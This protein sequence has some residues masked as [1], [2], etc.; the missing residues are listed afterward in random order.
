[1]TRVFAIVWKDALVRFSSKMEILFFL[2]LPVLFT[3]LLSGVGGGS[4]ENIPL[5][6]VDQ[7]ASRLSS[8]LVKALTRNTD[9]AVTV[10][11]RA[12]AESQFQNRQAVAWVVIPA[13]L[14]AELMTNRPAT[15]ELYKATGNASADVAEQAVSS[16]VRSVNRSIAVALTSTAVAERLRPFAEIA[17]RQ[18]YFMTSLTAAQEITA[19]VPKRLVVAR[20][21]TQKATLDER[22]QASIGQ[23]V[24][25]VLIPLLGTSVL[26]AYERN[27][28]TLQ[29]LLTTPTRKATYLSG[30]I[31]GQ[32]AVA[33]VQMVVLML[34][35]IYVMHVPWG[36]SPV[37][38]AIMMV[39]FGLASVALGT[40]L[41][42]FIKTERQA[43]NLSILL[44]MVLS[45]LGGCWWPLEF[46][47][48][49]MQTIAKALPTYWAMQGFSDLV[50]HGFGPTAI[51]L[52]AGILLLF[53]GAFFL[54]GL[55]RFRYE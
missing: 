35:G 26:F 48:P 12:E 55:K 19:T 11:T 10:T 43:N 2:L 20:A 47:P 34:F 7:D 30:T 6:V 45:L 29:R 53:A 44:G 22:A 51:W 54:I 3:F 1:M 9:L 38:L 25:W 49:T 4:A 39:S 33:M 50:L 21:A 5:L 27:G 46:F 8:V 36:Q 40:T 14:D 52:E 31:I 24:S 17:D 32:L 18:A 15:L 37:G 28:K 23:L 13:G 16:A 42:T 41:G